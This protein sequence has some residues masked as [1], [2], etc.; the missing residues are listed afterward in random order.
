MRT[1]VDYAF[2]L[3][4]PVA[5]V[6]VHHDRHV[7][8]LTRGSAGTDGSPTGASTCIR[9]RSMGRDNMIGG[10]RTDT[11]GEERRR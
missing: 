8:G 1:V 2:L 6:I 10:T 9:N 5:R 4:E 11:A 7:E 3:R